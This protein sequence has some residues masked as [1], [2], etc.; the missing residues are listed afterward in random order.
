MLQPFEEL[1]RLCELNRPLRRG[2]LITIAQRYGW[3]LNTEGGKGSHFKL[4]QSN[5]SSITLHD[6][7]YYA[8]AVRDCLREIVQPEIDR[9]V[10]ERYVNDIVARLEHFLS[11]LEVQ[12]LEIVTHQA[13]IAY[14]SFQIELQKQRQ[15][16]QDSIDV[17]LDELEKLR[18]QTLADIDSV[19]ALRS[20]IK[21]LENGIRRIYE[22][23]ITIKN[24]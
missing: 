13:H 19:E 11:D 1:I 5:Y 18:S 21:A 15:L 24:A 23:R 9:L 4:E 14:Q 16:S 7:E 22:W 20:R 12:A 17:E 10:N 8:S 3:T 2:F 6:N